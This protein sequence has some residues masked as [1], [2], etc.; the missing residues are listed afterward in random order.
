MNAPSRIFVS[1]EPVIICLEC[2][3]VSAMMVMNWT[4]QEGTA[5]VQPSK[6]LNCVI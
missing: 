1:L 6:G 4:E 3:I 2:F 5:Q